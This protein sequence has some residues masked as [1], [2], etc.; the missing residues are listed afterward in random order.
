[1]TSSTRMAFAMPASIRDSVYD[2]GEGLINVD[3]YVEEGRKY[4]FRKITFIG[5]TKYSTELLR[6]ILRIEKGD[7]FD[8]KTFE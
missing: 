7:V 1:M 3:V 8:S 6:K 4:Y 2:V 5:N